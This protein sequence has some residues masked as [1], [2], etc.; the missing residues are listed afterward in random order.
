MLDALL[1]EC[2]K[3]EGMMFK[4]CSKFIVILQKPLENFQCNEMRKNI[5]DKNYAKFRCN[6]AK[7]IDIL[8]SETLE[9]KKK[10]SHFRNGATNT[11]IAT[12]YEVDKLVTPDYF[13]K[14]IEDICTHGIHYFLSLEAA[15]YYDCQNPINGQFLRFYDNGQKWVEMNYVDG[16]VEGKRTIWHYDG[17][18]QSCDIFKVGVIM[19]HEN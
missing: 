6:G 15:F 2:K 4:R 9:H 1:E 8:H 18:I 10:I 17:Q 3:Y 7:V 12:V 14:N 16:Y 11:E 13:D 5:K 19:V